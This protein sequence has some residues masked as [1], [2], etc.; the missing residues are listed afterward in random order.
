VNGGY[1][2]AF[3][4]PSGFQSGPNQLPHV[5]QPGRLMTSV[6]DADRTV[7]TTTGYRCRRCGEWHDELPFTYHAAAP[8]YWSSERAADPGSVLGEEQCVIEPDQFFV[9]GLA[10]CR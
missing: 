9:R 8:A 1:S 4:S 2:S 6:A 10:G 3:N 7:L 5:D